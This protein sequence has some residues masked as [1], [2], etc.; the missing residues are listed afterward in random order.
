[1]EADI[2]PSKAQWSLYFHSSSNMALSAVSFRLSRIS[3]NICRQEHIESLTR[4][5][6]LHFRDGPFLVFAWELYIILQ[7]RWDCRSLLSDCSAV[8]YYSMDTQVCLIHTTLWAEWYSISFG[9]IYFMYV[10]RNL[11]FVWFYLISTI[12]FVF[13]CVMFTLRYHMC[14]YICVFI[15]KRI[16]WVNY[17]TLLL[18]CFIAFIRSVVPY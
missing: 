8:L 18:N 11:R 10:L 7:W 12:T 6:K 16:Q 15:W 2:L 9:D 17:V 13:I 3:M 5:F 14:E 1:M 4:S